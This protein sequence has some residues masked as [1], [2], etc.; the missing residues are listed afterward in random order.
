MKQHKI[1]YPSEYIVYDLE[2]TS[3][4]K[5]AAEVIEFAFKHVN[6]EE[7]T[8]KRFE[9]LVK[10]KEPIIAKTTEITGITQKMLNE[11]GVELSTAIKVFTEYLIQY[12]DLPIVGHNICDYDN[13][14]M[15]RLIMEEHAAGRIN[16]IQLNLMER[17]LQDKNCIDTAAIYKASRLDLPRKWN[18]TH[19]VYYKRVI[20]QR[21]YGLKFNLSHVAKELKVDVSDLTPHRAL[22]DVEMTSRVYQKMCL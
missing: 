10:P 13:I 6:V 9:V 7:S 11:E 12:M 16:D 1:T 22:S 4:D 5:N 14:I 15:R 19:E 17:R 20:E 3:L 21:V 18:E 8:E 2:T